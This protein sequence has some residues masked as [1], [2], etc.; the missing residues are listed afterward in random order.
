[1]ISQ[2]TSKVTK[3]SETT[4]PIMPQAKSEIWAKKRE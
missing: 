1:M 2:K 4:R 3:L